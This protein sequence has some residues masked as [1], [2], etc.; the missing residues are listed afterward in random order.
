M[1][2][3]TR[4]DIAQHLKLGKKAEARGLLADLLRHY[5]HDEEAWLAMAGLVENPAQ[6]RECLSRVL[7]INPKNKSA[8]QSLARLDSGEPEPEPAG[9]GSGL[10]RRQ[11]PAGGRGRRAPVP[12][13]M[14]QTLIGT[15]VVAALVFACGGFWAVGGFSLFLP[16]TPIPD[17]ATSTFP[18]PLPSF[19]PTPVTPTATLFRLATATWTPLP[20]LTET[21]TLTTPN[22]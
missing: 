18:T 7:A 2:A 5:P 12:R 16:P 20:T 9:P 13:W 6:K 19:T 17:T 4:K 21:A 11:R 1:D 3:Q 14:W 10:K 15:A 8:R 22:P